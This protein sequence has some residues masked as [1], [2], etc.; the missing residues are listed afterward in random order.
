MYATMGPAIMPWSSSTD[1][2]TNSTQALLCFGILRAIC[3]YLDIEGGEMMMPYHPTIVTEDE[4]SMTSALSDEQRAKQL[5]V[6]F[7]KVHSYEAWSKTNAASERVFG[8][9]WTAQIAAGAMSRPAEV[10]TAMAEGKPYPVKAYIT[11]GSDPL[12]GYTDPKH[13]SLIHI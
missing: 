5:G 9:P 2:Q 6:T 7:A 12:T 4:I 11:V 3:G 1:Q 10:W 8:R 13:L